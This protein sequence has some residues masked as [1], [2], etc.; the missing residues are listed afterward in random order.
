MLSLEEALE[1]ARADYGILRTDWR[2]MSRAEI[3]RI[4]GLG[5]CRR[6]HGQVQLLSRRR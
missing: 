4:D 1:S 2:A 3:A 5:D 6:Q